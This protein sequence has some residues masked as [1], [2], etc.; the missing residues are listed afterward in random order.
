MPAYLCEKPFA[1]E[2]PLIYKKT[3]RP[4]LRQSC[5]S[6]KLFACVSAAA[7]RTSVLHYLYH[8]SILISC[9][10]FFLVSCIKVSVEEEIQIPA[11]FRI[12][13]AAETEGRVL[14]FLFFDDDPLG[15]LDS[16][17]RT[18]CTD[19]T[20]TGTVCGSGKKI[21]VAVSSEGRDIYDY[22]D[23]RDF[24]TLSSKERDFR[25]E[26]PSLP[27]LSGQTRSGEAAIRLLP[28]LTKI[29]INSLLAD[30]HNHPYS[31]SQMENVKIYLTNIPASSPILGD[32]DA[33]PSVWL[34][35][36]GF[37]EDDLA[38][39]EHPEMIFSQAG[40]VGREVVFP[41]TELYCFP[42]GVKVESFGAPLSK[43]VFEAVIDG[44]TWY[45]PILL[46]DLERGRMYSLDITFT[47][48]GTKDPET[49]VSR[50]DILVSTNIIP[51]TEKEN[52]T[53][54]F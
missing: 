28:L 32:R 14:D 9:P 50:E 54:L 34:N 46:K 4:S 3:G 38:T 40:N 31:A 1:M 39:L 5:G 25:A 48:K 29:R 53:V 45:Y 11:R 43:L 52:I 15:R 30:F 35:L 26:D 20:A 33:P 51:W 44:E 13:S 10:A 16:F 19:G 12:S 2:T 8:L 36:G 27:S 47:G 6:K 42:S 17:S 21:I 41:G 7:A 18:V 37:F 24:Q 22:A 49:P 23:I